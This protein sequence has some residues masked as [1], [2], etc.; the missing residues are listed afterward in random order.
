M[1]ER[2]YWTPGHIFGG[3]WGIEDVMFCFHAGVIS[4]LCALGPWGNKV[5][6][7]PVASVVF[8]RIFVVSLF[9]T[10]LLG[11]CLLVF[12][13]TIFSAFLLVQTASTA[14]ILII[15]PSYLRLIFYSAP[16]FTVY[17]FSLLALWRFFLPSFMDMWNGTELTGSQ[18][19]GVPVEEYIW[20]LSFCTGFPITMSFALDAR[21]IGRSSGLIRTAIDV[22]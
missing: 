15:R 1:Y 22:H 14:I 17:Y 13:V 4:W 7:Y 10:I 9:A 6:I 2:V 3:G 21:F 5:C 12:R 8:R 19:L 11:V 18:F 20:V 16:L